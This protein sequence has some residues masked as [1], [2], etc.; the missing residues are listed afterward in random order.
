MVFM[1]CFINA[2]EW[3][4]RPQTAGVRQQPDATTRSITAR[5]GGWS[6][7]RPAGAGRVQ[8]GL[9]A[10]AWDEPGDTPSR[11]LTQWY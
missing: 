1:A 9:R 8:A 5:Q 2:G 11:V 7:T 3:Q 4:R 10:A 6:A